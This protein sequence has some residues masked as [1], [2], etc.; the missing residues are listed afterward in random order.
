MDKGNIKSILAIDNMSVRIVTKG[1]QQ[2][3]RQILRLLDNFENKKMQCQHATNHQYKGHKILDRNMH[4]L[5]A[6]CGL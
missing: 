4:M 3:M 2:T 1:R 5:G 6:P